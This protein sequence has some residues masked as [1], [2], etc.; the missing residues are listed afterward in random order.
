[1]ESRNTFDL[2][3]LFL[4]KQDDAVV[5][6]GPS[7]GESREPLSD[8]KEVVWLHRAGGVGSAGAG[9]WSRPVFAKLKKPGGR[10]R[11]VAAAVLQKGKS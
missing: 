5:Q 8:S 9:F 2:Q 10:L 6:K 7:G 1:M 11:R 3:R 4:A